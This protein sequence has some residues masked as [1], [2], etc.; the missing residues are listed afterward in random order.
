[1]ESPQIIYI[2]SSI[3]ELELKCLGNDECVNL[4]EERKK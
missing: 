3:E 4:E 1:M 2:Q